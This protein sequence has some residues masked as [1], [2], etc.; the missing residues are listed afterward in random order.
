MKLQKN[1]VSS[2]E[3]KIFSLSPSENSEGLSFFGSVVKKFIFEN[4]YLNKLYFKCLILN[5]DSKTNK[6][7]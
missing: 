6:N 7:N 4:T 2:Q 5:Q 3:M 1:I